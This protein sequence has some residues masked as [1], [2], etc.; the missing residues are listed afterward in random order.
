[1]KI[2]TVYFKVSGCSTQRFKYVIEDESKIE[3]II[4]KEMKGL[5]VVK[6]KIENLNF[7]NGYAYLNL[8]D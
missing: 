6:T 1:M 7:K 2:L 4:E 8:I 3:E 5:N